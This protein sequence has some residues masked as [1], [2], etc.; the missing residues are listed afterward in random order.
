ML[1]IRNPD[2][3]WQF[4]KII[5]VCVGDHK[6]PA[7]VVSLKEFSINALLLHR[8]PTSLVSS[9]L[10]YELPKTFAIKASWGHN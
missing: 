10:L 5:Q 1:T 2:L 9:N 7:L 6:L 4:A 8:L 3:A